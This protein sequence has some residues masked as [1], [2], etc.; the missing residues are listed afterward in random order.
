MSC[1]ILGWAKTV[2]LRGELRKAAGNLDGLRTIPA[3]VE[4]GRPVLVGLGCTIRFE[5]DF[6]AH[7]ADK[8]IWI[9]QWHL[10]LWQSFSNR[11]GSR[12]M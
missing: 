12:H 8:H 2:Y 1:Q 7:R 9:P 11:S 6:R 10:F 5:E 3:L 4:L